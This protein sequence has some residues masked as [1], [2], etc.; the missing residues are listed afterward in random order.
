MLYNSKVPPNTK[1]L[2][3]YKFKIRIDKKYSLIINPVINVL[4]NNFFCVCKLLIKRN[5]PA[6]NKPM[7]ELKKPKQS[8]IKQLM[9]SFI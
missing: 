2:D 9:P 8:N 4:I 6:I 1:K 3:V 5:A 7:N